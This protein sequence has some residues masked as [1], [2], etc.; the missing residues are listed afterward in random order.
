MGAPSKRQLEESKRKVN[1]LLTEDRLQP[2]PTATPQLTGTQPRITYPHEQ[3]QYPE[4]EPR[5]PTTPKKPSRR[6]YA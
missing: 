1:E 5:I 4:Y 3:M 6:S 2:T